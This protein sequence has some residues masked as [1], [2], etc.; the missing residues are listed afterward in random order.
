MDIDNSMVK[1]PD[2]GQVW[3]GAGQWR[4]KAD[5]CN[6]FNN[7]D[8]FLKTNYIT[9]RGPMHK[10]CARIGLCSSGGCLSP[11]S[12]DFV[13]KVVQKDVWTVGRSTVQPFGQFAYY[14][15][16]IIDMFAMNNL[17]DIYDMLQHG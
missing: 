2:G 5:I 6:T 14:T 16:I 7:N 10:M 3:G 12:S 1:S 15:F 8:K 17:K 13:P 11:C 4:K 9:S